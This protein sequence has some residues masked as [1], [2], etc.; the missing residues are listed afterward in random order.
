MPVI[1]VHDAGS[2]V[3]DIGVLVKFLVH[4]VYKRFLCVSVGPRRI[5]SNF[6][7]NFAFVIT[8][9]FSAQY[10]VVRLL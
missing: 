5:W 4:D 8:L 6:A 9:L 2:I 1:L 7:I 10:N 3:R